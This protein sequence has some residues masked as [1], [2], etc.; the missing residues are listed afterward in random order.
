VREI[1]RTPLTVGQIV[2]TIKAAQ[3]LGFEGFVGFHFYNEPT[4]YEDRIERVMSQVDARYMLWSNGK[5][6]RLHDRFEWVFVTPYEQGAN[7]DDRM[8]NYEGQ[9]W[10]RAC[11]R[12]LIECPIDYSGR[13][14]LCCQDWRIMDF[15][16]NYQR[17]FCRDVE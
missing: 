5:S 8:L 10:D 15:R 3:S 12:P 16:R 14:A 17:E 4:L 1:D 6:T 13:I 7:F 2:D 11:W 9:G